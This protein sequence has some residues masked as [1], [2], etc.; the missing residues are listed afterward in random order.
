M[1]QDSPPSTSRPGPP[2]WAAQMLGRQALGIISEVLNETDTEP[3]IRL[4]LQR[5]LDDNPGRPERALLAHLH[6]WQE[7]ER[8]P[9]E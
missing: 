5:H 2:A 7:R 1:E 4:G 9:Q 6:D 3:N 8:P